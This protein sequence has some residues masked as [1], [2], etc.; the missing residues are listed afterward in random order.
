MPPDSIR[1]DSGLH[2][3]QVRADG[4]DLIAVECAQNRTGSDVIGVR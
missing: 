3:V 2:R 1:L 4:V